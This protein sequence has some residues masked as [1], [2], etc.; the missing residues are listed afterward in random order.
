MKI[1]QSCVDHR[2]IVGLLKSASKSHLIQ[3]F[4]ES[5]RKYFI[6]YFTSGFDVNWLLLVG[7]DKVPLGGIPA[8][9]WLCNRHSSCIVA[10]VQHSF[11]C[12]PTYHLPLYLTYLFVFPQLSTL[13]YLLNYLAFLFIFIRFLKHFC[14]WLFPFK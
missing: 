4:V 3:L 12:L 10:V 13:P 8:S 7:R 11:L 2:S 9:H 6:P 5:T 1:L 14:F